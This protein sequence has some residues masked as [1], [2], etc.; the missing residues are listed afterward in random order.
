M[1]FEEFVNEKKKQID[2]KKEINKEIKKKNRE[3][4][5]KSGANLSTKVIHKHHI[6][7]KHVSY[8]ELDED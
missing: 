3:D 5:L 6:P 1:N 4:Q 2:V 7:S 8:K